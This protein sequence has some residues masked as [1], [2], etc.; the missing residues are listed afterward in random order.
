MPPQASEENSQTIQ[1]LEGTQK[2]VSD[3]LVDRQTKLAQLQAELDQLE[4]GVD[5]LLDLKRQVM[6]LCWDRE[7]ENQVTLPVVPYP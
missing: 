7:A 1:E 5:S 2:G 4:P 3:S 6:H